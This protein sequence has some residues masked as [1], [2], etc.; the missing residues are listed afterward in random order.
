LDEAAVEPL[1]VQPR[2]QNAPMEL[3]YQAA[4]EVALLLSR[5]VSTPD[6]NIM[7]DRRVGSK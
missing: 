1:V 7:V 3:V 2:P 6:E 4:P 5:A